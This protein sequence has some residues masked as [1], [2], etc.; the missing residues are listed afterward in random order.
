MKLDLCGGDRPKKGFTNTDIRYIPGVNIL[1]DLANP[2]P[3]RDNTVDEIWSV[4]TIEHF[5]LQ[6]VRWILKEFFRI[7]KP[8]AVINI[9]VPNLE[10]LITAWTEKSVDLTTFLRYL[11]G[12]QSNPYDFHARC[13]M[14]G[15]LIQE[16]SRVFGTA[17]A[18]KY[19]FPRHERRFMLQVEAIKRN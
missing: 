4:A 5:G 19:T 10:A 11:Y 8:G 12:E 13:W 3:F 6:A 15:D 1:L 9:A 18:V 17:S 14:T 2:L 7:L 16:V